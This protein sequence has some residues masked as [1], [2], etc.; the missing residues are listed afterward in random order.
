MDLER[1]ESDYSEAEIHGQ[2]MTIARV[3]DDKSQ[4]FTKELT[5]VNMDSMFLVEC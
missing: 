5:W 1:L 2:S 3:S 4:I